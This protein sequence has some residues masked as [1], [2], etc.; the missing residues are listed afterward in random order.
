MDPDFSGLAKAAYQ[1][2]K[3]TV[4]GGRQVAAWAL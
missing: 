2:A 4:D 3:D 1:D